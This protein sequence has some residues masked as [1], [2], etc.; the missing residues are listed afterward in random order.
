MIRR[1]PR[2]TLFPYTT[3]FRSMEDTNGNSILLNYAPAAGYGWG[4]TNTSS[5]IYQIFDAR[6]LGYS[7]GG[8]YGGAGNYQFTYNN[9]DYPPHLT[10]ITNTLGTTENYSFSTAYQ[11]L[12]EPFGLTSRG[13]VTMLTAATVTGLNIANQFQY[14][15]LRAS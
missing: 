2:S 11:Q 5:R 15:S 1:P 12:L 9:Y 4:N 8:C 6:C 7:Q 3:L 10:G 13:Y 14:D